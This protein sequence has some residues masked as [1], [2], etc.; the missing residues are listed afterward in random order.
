MALEPRKLLGHKERLGK[1]ALN[2]ARP[3]HRQLILFGEF[4]DAQDGNDVLEVL[5]FLQDGF[6]GPRHAVML[7]ADDARIQHA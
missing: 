4:I 2:L 7:L 3:R 5:V 6:H 1:E